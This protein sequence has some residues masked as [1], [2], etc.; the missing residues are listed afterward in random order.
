MN[1]A[2]AGLKLWRLLVR[3]RQLR[4]ERKRRALA[5]AQRAAQRA[6]EDAMQRRA[7]LQLHE[8]Q[9]SRILESCGH[10]KQA[11]RLWRDTLRWHDARK[12]ALYR[13]LVGAMQG[14]RAAAADVSRASTSL[15]R[16]MM[17]QQDAQTRVRRLNAA[18]R[19]D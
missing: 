8:A 7:A 6:D 13:A 2:K 16:E 19:D 4:V 11:A 12:D 5:D 15:Q 17:G 18:L 14:Q 9:R 3:V 10:D 1:D